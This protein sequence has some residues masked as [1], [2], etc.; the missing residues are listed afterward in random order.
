MGW[1]HAGPAYDSELQFLGP[2]HDVDGPATSNELG[3]ALPWRR[4]ENLHHGDA[5][6]PATILS[7]GMRG[8]ARTLPR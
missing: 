2:M 5:C 7:T 4:P 6:N 8:T 1:L 3:R